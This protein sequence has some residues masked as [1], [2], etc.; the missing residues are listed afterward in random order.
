MSINNQK[1]ILFVPVINILPLLFWA[2]M[3]YNA[4]LKISYFMKEFLK[5]TVCILSITVL[6]LVII[7]FWPGIGQSFIT[8][9]IFIY[10]YFTSIAYLSIGAQTKL[11]NN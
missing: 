6:R 2:K 7:N 5:L 1:K 10:L 11:N 8:S 4:S 3:C 9:M